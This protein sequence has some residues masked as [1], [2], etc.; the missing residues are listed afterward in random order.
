M[1]ACLELPLQGSG[2]P[3]PSPVYGG[4]VLDP[5]RDATFGITSSLSFLV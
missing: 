4:H 2:P 3:F 5:S 1:R